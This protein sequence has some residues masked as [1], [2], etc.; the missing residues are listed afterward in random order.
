[1]WLRHK[2]TETRESSYLAHISHALQDEADNFS[3]SRVDFFISYIGHVGG[4]RLNV[5]EGEKKERGHHTEIIFLQH[6]S[7]WATTHIYTCDYNVSGIVAHL[8]RDPFH[9]LLLDKSNPD[10][11]HNL[12]KNHYNLWLLWTVERSRRICQKYTKVCLSLPAC[13]FQ[14]WFQLASSNLQLLPLIFNSAR[15]IVGREVVC[16]DDS[17]Q[18]KP[19]RVVFAVSVSATK[20]L[21]Y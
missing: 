2:W 18:L 11:E 16:Q 15:R 8:D 20:S 10:L 12:V 3:S 5:P 6:S 17:Q 13:W 1:M 19:D 14:L 21:V 9:T 7:T 4:E